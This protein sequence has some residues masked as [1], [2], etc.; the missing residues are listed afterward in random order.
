MEHSPF[1]HDVPTKSA[2]YRGFPIA[3][4]EGTGGYTVHILI[5]INPIPQ[6]S[7]PWYVLVFKGITGG[8]D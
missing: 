4:F 8:R 2:I 6:Q 1:I 7:H 5:I 3:M